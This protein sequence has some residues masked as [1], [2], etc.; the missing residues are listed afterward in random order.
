MG[1]MFKHNTLCHRLWDGVISGTR[2]CT[3][4]PYWLDDGGQPNMILNWW[5]LEMTW[6]SLFWHLLAMF[7]DTWAELPSESKCLLDVTKNIN[8]SSKWMKQGYVVI[9]HIHI[10]IIWLSSRPLC[11]PNKLSIWPV[12]MYQFLKRRC[13]RHPGEQHRLWW[14]SHGSHQ[15]A[16]VMALLDSGIHQPQPGGQR[17][18]GPNMT[19]LYMRSR[20]NS[21]IPQRILNESCIG[22]L[23]ERNFEELPQE[24]CFEFSWSSSG[25]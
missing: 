12:L 25:R 8:H 22:G 19:F 1:R 17:Q 2:F 6:V 20:E 10:Y 21:W 14:S 16:D 3:S 13:G 9:L 15:Q 23:V 24:T 18:G 4:N 7:Q 11:K 5:Y